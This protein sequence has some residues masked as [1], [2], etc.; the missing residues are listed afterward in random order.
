MTVQINNILTI[1]ASSLKR[2]SGVTLH[3][4]VLA[5]LG[6][7]FQPSVVQDCLTP[8]CPVTTA[9]LVALKDGAISAPDCRVI[10]RRVLSGAE[11][12]LADSRLDQLFKSVELRNTKLG[13]AH[14]KNAI[15][16]M[17]MYGSLTV[18]S[19]AFLA[20]SSLN[21]GRLSWA[22]EILLRSYY[23]AGESWSAGDS[24]LG[25]DSLGK[26]I[27]EIIDC[28]YRYSSKEELAGH[29][30]QAM[31]SSPDGRIYQ[32][33]L[34]HLRGD[35]PAA[36]PTQATA[37]PTTTT[38]ENTM[39]HAATAVSALVSSLSAAPSAVLPMLNASLGAVCQGVTVEKIIEAMREEVSLRTA[40]ETKHE[41]ELRVA[42]A[43]AAS[44]GQIT[45]PQQ[46]KGAQVIPSGTVTMVP[47]SSL[48]KEM[49]NLSLMVPK[50]TWDAPHPDVPEVNPDY[51]F[52]KS[53]LIPVLRSLASG[54]ECVWAKG[55]TGSGKTTLF[56]QVAA[57]LGWPMMRV[58]MD[59]NVDRSALVGRLNLQAD[60]NGGTVSE[61]LSGVLEEAL[62]GGYI[63]LLDELDASHRNS[64]YVVQSLLENKGIRILEDGGRSVMPHPFFRVVATGNTGGNGDDSGLY[65]ATNVLSAATLDRFTETV[66]V[67]YVTKS[68]EE[69]L[70]SKAAP[71][72]D[73]P[74]LTR[75]AKFAA[76][77]RNA[78]VNR[79][80]VVSY[81][82]R[83]SM[84]LARAVADYMDMGL[85]EAQALATAAVGK[86]INP[87]PA[88]NKARIEELV[89]TALGA[90]PKN[91]I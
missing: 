34:S 35:A 21:E 69:L 48:F 6:R 54:K 59:G 51:I 27:S 52:R 90:E 70:L 12:S 81:S 26:V 62:A 82:P 64:I 13:V 76:E 55:H 16:V 18:K 36:A 29:I 2:S 56:E 50:F 86:V 1:P 32:A 60:A 57:V 4:D 37:V 45:L 67:P 77:F 80:V 39:N 41:A 72:L 49:K 71:S 14:S 15:T 73:K 44:S 83:R 7:Q 42:K 79:E 61:W 24:I 66:E 38:K 87:A 53:L 28:N 74:M 84:A 20:A 8:A 75:L 63:L 25:F 19:A 89:R 40:M 5:L 22:T 47:A 65:P 85:S 33:I 3:D 68:E 30:T 9:A 10:F 91:A 88:E 23:T 17:R 46:S 58:A 11:R 43:A 31:L 78:F